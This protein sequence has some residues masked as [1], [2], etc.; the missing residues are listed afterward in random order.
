MAAID[1]KYE[2]M[3]ATS[4]IQNAAASVTSDISDLGT[5]YTAFDVAETPDIGEGG[6]LWLNVRVATAMTPATTGLVLTL[7]TH[8]SPSIALGT[9]L[10]AKTISSAQAA[11]V[12]LWR[13]KI[14]AGT[15]SRYLGMTA[16]CNAT[17][18]TAGAIDAWIGL[19]SESELPSA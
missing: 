9:A 18:C 5:G 14:P 10:A 19:D 3:D 11:G 4:I 2:F 8:T 7:Y 1:K 17:T 6:D 16:L 12:S 13:Q 15:I